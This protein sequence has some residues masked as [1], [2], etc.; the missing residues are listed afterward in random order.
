MMNKKKILV[1]TGGSVFVER[2]VRLTGNIFRKSESDI[3]LLC[4]NDPSE[5]IDVD[6]SINIA[7]DI[8]KEFGIQPSA[9]V[10]KGHPAKEILS[11][12]VEGYD[13]V[14]MGSHGTKGILEFFLG[15]TAVQV[16]ENLKV[17]T[18]IVRGKGEINNILMPVRLGKEKDELLS[19]TG[20]IARAINSKVTI[21]YVIPL[22]AMYGIHLKENIELLEKHPSEAA[23]IRRV[24][25]EMEEEYGIKSEIRLRE[26]VPEEEILEEAEEGNHDM[27][28]VGSSS[29][30]GISGLILGNL[31][32]TIVKHSKQSVV[33][34]M[35]RKR[36]G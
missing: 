22:P 24:A 25:A 11:E 15:D 13:L 31:S 18:M 2:A 32:Y 36:S 17:S 12:S 26:G 16:I 27:I 28:V 3:T 35:P 5:S 34:V 30:R 21:L 9:K 8:L 14:V 10:R 1:G 33:V 6:K 4:V 20:E 19:V 7:K 29:W 23:H